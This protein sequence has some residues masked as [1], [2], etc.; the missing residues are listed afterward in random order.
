LK[1]GEE[2]YESLLNMGDII[3]EKRGGGGHQSLLNMGQQIL[4]MIYSMPHINRQKKENKQETMVCVSTTSQLC[5]I[6]QI[7]VYTSSINI[8]IKQQMLMPSN[9]H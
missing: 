3:F 9:I 6:F 7:A 8:Y 4:Q 1:K 2:G 5:N